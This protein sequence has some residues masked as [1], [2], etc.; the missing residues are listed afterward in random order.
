MKTFNK[1]MNEAI[2]GLGNVDK[3]RYLLD[4]GFT[5]SQVVFILGKVGVQTKY[6]NP[7]SYQY[8]NNVATKPRPTKKT[9]KATVK[10]DLK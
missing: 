8:V 7:V 4:E 3:I 5:T 10:F 1:T 6:G 9:V 2:K